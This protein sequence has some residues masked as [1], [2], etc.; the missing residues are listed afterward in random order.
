VH[1]YDA[2]DPVVVAPQDA[3]LD[4]ALLHG[5]VRA[6]SQVAHPVV[7]AC[8]RPSPAIAV[9]AAS[10]SGSPDGA[11]S[12]TFTCPSTSAT[13]CCR[14]RSSSSAPPSPKSRW[15]GSISRRPLR[16]SLARR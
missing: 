14:P 5:S 16:A 2:E 10:S 1:R 8:P 4:E 3:D 7:G 12:T 11:S 15:S 13:H 6:P 9:T